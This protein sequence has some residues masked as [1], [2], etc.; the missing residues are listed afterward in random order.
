M[1]WM[2]ITFYPVLGKNTWVRYEIL[3]Q[4]K[5]SDFS[6]RCSS[7][8]IYGLATPEAVTNVSYYIVSRLPCIF[9]FFFFF[10]F[11]LEKCVIAVWR[12]RVLEFILKF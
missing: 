12:L 2:H 1:Q 9:F 5:T 6:I 10:F 8:I 7:K 3:S 4:A 11:F